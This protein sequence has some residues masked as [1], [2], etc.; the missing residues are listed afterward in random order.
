MSMSAEHYPSRT[1]AAS[2]R[3]QAGLV[4]FIV[5][6]L[7]LF[8]ILAI[9][10]PPLAAVAGLP[11]IGEGAFWFFG[12]ICHQLPDRSFHLMGHQLGVCSR[13]FGVYFGLLAG[14]LA[15]PLWRQIDE[16]EPLPRV[17]L[18]ASIIPMV[19]DWSLTFFG[20]WENTHA[21]RFLTGLI[22]GVGC[23]TFIIPAVVEIARYTLGRPAPAS[24]A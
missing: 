2:R 20:I 13:C 12:Y 17:F 24:T 23:A 15:Y 21:S 4:W 7:V 9:L 14:V 1:A 10:L 18:F 16:I 5:T 19:I 8:W 6:L 22:L 3:R 11:Q